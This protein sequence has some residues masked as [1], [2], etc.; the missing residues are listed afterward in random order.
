MAV[1]LCTTAAVNPADNRQHCNQTSLISYAACS[2]AV[3]AATVRLCLSPVT[4]L[5]LPTSSLMPA[6]PKMLLAGL[7]SRSPGHSE[8]AA[9]WCCG[10]QSKQQTQP[11]VALEMSG[12]L[13]EL[14]DSCLGKTDAH[15]MYSWHAKAQHNVNCLGSTR[16][17]YIVG[18]RDRVAPNCVFSL[19]S[20]GLS[21]LLLVCP[22]WLLVPTPL[23]SV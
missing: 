6:S 7:W 12:V 21:S 3:A 2:A 18:S 17:A 9:T 23:R 14:R 20:A 15:C 22:T 13:V 4:Q 1:L 10:Q 11:T 19:H 5:L 8:A 16:V